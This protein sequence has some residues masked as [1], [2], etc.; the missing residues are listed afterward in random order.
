MTENISPAEQRHAISTLNEVFGY[1]TDM[2]FNHLGI[3]T[4]MTSGLIVAE[5]EVKYGNVTSSF[6]VRINVERYK[7]RDMIAS[8]PIYHMAFNGHSNSP[9]SNPK[10]RN[11]IL[12]DIE[13]AAA[14]TN[15]N[16]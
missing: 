16:H 12:E 11:K 10:Y 7:N 8:L 3:T 4:T 6:D 9:I 2:E 1:N 5:Y 13:V 15:R 14:K